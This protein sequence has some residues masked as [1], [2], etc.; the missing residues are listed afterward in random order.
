[1]SLCAKNGE[2]GCMWKKYNLQE[3][4]KGKNLEKKP[5]SGGK[6]LWKH[7]VDTSADGLHMWCFTNPNVKKRYRRME[8]EDHFWT[9]FYTMSSKGSF[10]YNML[11]W[12]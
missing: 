7:L 3:Q 12:H 11:L 5:L 9:P 1:M 4:F 6:W 10:M 8:R 2:Q